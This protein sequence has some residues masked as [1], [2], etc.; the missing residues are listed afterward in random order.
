MEAIGCDVP[1]VCEAEAD[2]K[3][4]FQGLLSCFS[5]LNV[6]FQL[7]SHGNETLNQALLAYFGVRSL[8]TLDGQCQHQLWIGFVLNC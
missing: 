4:E 8:L 5:C 1:A 7:H 2:A 3:V 6:E